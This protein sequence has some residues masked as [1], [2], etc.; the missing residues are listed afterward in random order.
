MLF[1]LSGEVEAGM[2]TWRRSPSEVEANGLSQGTVLTLAPFCKSFAPA[3]NNDLGGSRL[4]ERLLT[5]CLLHWCGRAK[6]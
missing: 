4:Q 2:A 6:Y 1:R 3:A 5:D